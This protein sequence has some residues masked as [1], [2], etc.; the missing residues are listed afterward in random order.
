VAVRVLDVP[1]SEAKPPS[2]KTFEVLAPVRLAEPFEA[3]RD[4][5][6]A[7]L[8]KTGARPKVFLATLGKLSE[9]NA[10]AMFAKN[11]YEAGGIDATMSDGFRDQAAMIAAFKDSGARL[12]CLCSS[13][14]IYA[15]EAA[16]AASALKQAGA[17]V[18][19]A[20]R[21]GEHE[22]AWNK[23]GVTTYIYA[24]CDVLATLRAA[25]ET[26]DRA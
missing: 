6:D 15:D 12:A 8:A 11:F 16:A 19:L 4:K 13:D 18:L 25:H 9:F 17:T 24:G 23:A 1:R 7:I 10:R 22:N 2:P 21:P 26:L 20:G 5:S 3:L 14:K